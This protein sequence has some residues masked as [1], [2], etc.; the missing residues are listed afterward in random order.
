MSFFAMLR[1]LVSGRDLESEAVGLADAVEN[2]LWKLMERRAGSLSRHEIRGYVRA[3]AA[4][5]L[6][7]EIGQRQLP[8][9]SVVALRLLVLAELTSRL[10]LKLAYQPAAQLPRAA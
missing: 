7:A 1:S 8:A 4:R 2:Q 10:Q 6:D 9:K 3:R 5:V